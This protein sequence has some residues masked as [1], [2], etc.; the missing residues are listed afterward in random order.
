M[1]YK[2]SQ[3]HLE[4]FFSAVR[5]RGGF[6]NNPSCKQFKAAYKKLMM[7]VDPTLSHS[8]NIIKMDSTKILQA[9]CPKQLDL[10][11]TCSI[12]E[13]GIDSIIDDIE[14]D[15]QAKNDDD[16]ELLNI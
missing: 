4:T 6:N 13:N 14:Y 2:L 12:N 15:K 10:I 5:R 8:A 16:T 3:D 9:S 11:A 7:Y 1:T